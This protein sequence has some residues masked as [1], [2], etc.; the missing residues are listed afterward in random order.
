MAGKVIVASAA[1]TTSGDSGAV[2]VE[3]QEIDVQ[4][5]VSAV[6]G[7]SQTLDVEVEW[8]SDNGT[9]WVRAD[10]ADAFAQIIAVGGRVETFTKKGD[11]MRV[12]WTI[13]GTT[14]SFTFKV[15]ADYD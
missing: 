8:S 15:T 10:P 13:A 14:P 11:L 5:D 2:F 3:G 9:S 7:V 12:K 1:R 6:S 4:V